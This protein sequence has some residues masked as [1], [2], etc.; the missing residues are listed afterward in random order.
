[1][2]TMSSINDLENHESYI[3]PQQVNSLPT[4]RLFDYRHSKLKESTKLP[5]EFHILGSTYYQPESPQSDEFDTDDT[6]D[7]EVLFKVKFIGVNYEKDF[8]LLKNQRFGSKTSVVPGN[9]IIGKIVSPTNSQNFYLPWQLPYNDNS[10]YLVFPYSNCLI[11]NEH[12]YC[13]NC[14]HLH[15]L[16]V[17]PLTSHNYFQYKRYG[18][19]RNWE[20]GYNIDGGLQDYMKIKKPHESLIRIPDNISLHDCCFSLEIMLPFYSFL[21]DNFIDLSIKLEGRSLVVLNDVSKEIN[22]VLMVLKLLKIDQRLFWFID[23]EKI[24]EVQVYESSKYYYSS[25]FN[26]VFLFNTSSTSV[27]FGLDGAISTGLE[28]TKSRYNFAFF[29]QYD[30][31]CATKYKSINDSHPDKTIHHFRLSYKDK[32]YLMELMHFIADLNTKNKSEGSNSSV[33]N[34]PSE[35]AME[36]RPQHPPQ[37]RPSVTS[38]NTSTTTFSNASIHLNSTKSS[39][40]SVHLPRQL[41][42]KIAKN[43]RFRD[44]DS[45][46]DVEFQSSKKESNHYSWLYYDKDFDLCND[47]ECSDEEDDDEDSS[48]SNRQVFHSVKQMNRLIRSSKFSRVC[49]ANKSNKT[50]KINAFI[51]A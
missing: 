21:K 20:F 6:L 26:H 13:A 28:S 50:V 1:M 45:V 16:N 43:L 33:S 34:V 7:P 2:M 12:D 46:I 4:K 18:C 48:N 22:D 42:K 47:Y 37:P 3:M 8:E 36:E 40:S 23:P 30:P 10:K 15:K 24:R 19:L 9:K 27:L 25:R 32:L 49:Y 44:E 39:S 29:D 35:T 31:N 14:N 51:F 5:H 17:G 38:I 11:Q 41:G